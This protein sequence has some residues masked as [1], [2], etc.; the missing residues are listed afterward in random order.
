[1]L[2][3][4]QKYNASKGFTVRHLIRIKKTAQKKLLTE[5]KMQRNVN[6]K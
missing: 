3:K 6:K 2:P 4:I 5:K 1:M